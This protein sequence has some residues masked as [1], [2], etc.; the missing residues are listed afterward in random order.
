MANRI[1]P[2]QTARKSALRQNRRGQAK[3]TSQPVLRETEPS[4]AKRVNQT[5]A[6]N[7]NLTGASDV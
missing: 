3:G 7:W 1:N 4:F 2:I 6:E 5:T